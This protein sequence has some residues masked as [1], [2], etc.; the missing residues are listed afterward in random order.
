MIN[1]M[2]GD[3]LE[4]MRSIE[5]KSID[6]ILCDL[7]YGC[8]QNRWDE[9]LSFED[10]WGHYERIIKDNTPII[11]FSQGF[12]TA[13]MMISNKKMWRYNLVWNKINPSGH[14]NANRM[15]LRSHEDIC[16]FYKK[17]PYYNPQKTFGKKNHSKGKGILNTNNNYGNFAFVDNTDVLGNLK[18]PKSILSFKKP[19]PSNRIHPTEK[20]VPLLEYLINTYSQEGSLILDNC[21]GSGSTGVACLNTKRRFIGIEKHKKYFDIA[22]SRIRKNKT[23]LKLFK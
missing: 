11:L 22:V 12:F 8:T 5:D 17:L 13:E 6:M 18:H 10:L 19:A 3:C 16:I 21:M 23:Q 15:P 4:L 14:L 2:R 9:K 7:P 20:P 1:L